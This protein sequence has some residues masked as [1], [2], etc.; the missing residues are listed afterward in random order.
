MNDYQYELPNTIEEIYKSPLEM[1]N[2][3]NFLKKNT[4]RCLLLLILYKLK[5]SKRKE[6]ARMVKEDQRKLWY[7][8]VFLINKGLLIDYN[9][10]D[11]LVEEKY[12][13]LTK[14]IRKRYIEDTEGFAFHRKIPIIYYSLTKE[15]EDLIPFCCEVLNIKLTKADKNE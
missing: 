11:L 9:G 10:K 4:K 5:V 6:L 2:I 3:R 8:L 15:G 7:W 13:E 12:N 1:A 14:K